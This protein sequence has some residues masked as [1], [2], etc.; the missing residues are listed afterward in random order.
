MAG[1]SDSRIRCFEPRHATGVAEVA[2][3]LEWPSLSDPALVVNVFT[4]PGAS[5]EVALVGDRV[6]GF[7]QALGDGNLQSHLRTRPSWLK[8]GA[9]AW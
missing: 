4:A 1:M 3:V 5:A 6:V 7:A 2:R 9:G 8:V